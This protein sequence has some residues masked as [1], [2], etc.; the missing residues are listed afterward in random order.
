MRY[1]PN[2]APDA[3][4][5]LALSE[6]ER[7]RLVYTHY[8]AAGKPRADVQVQAAVQAVVETYLAMG[9][10]SASRA[11]SRLQAD[12]LTRLEATNAIGHVLDSFSR[13]LTCGPGS[14][15]N[16]RMN[17]ALDALSAAGWKATDGTR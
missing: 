3:S 14:E 2:V 13:E 1:D 16:G 4:Q 11:L 17:A 10:G 5:W 6:D 8:E 12:G 7:M 9:V 15:F